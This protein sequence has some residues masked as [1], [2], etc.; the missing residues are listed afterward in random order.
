MDEFIA[1]LLGNGGERSAQ[2]PTL[3]HGALWGDRSLSAEQRADALLAEM[4]LEEKSGMLYGRGLKVSAERNIWQAWVRGVDRLGVP[5]VT[6]GDSPAAPLMGPDDGMAIPSEH[7]LGATFDPEAAQRAAFVLGAQVRRMGYGVWHAP[8]LD[9]TRDPRH[10]R[11]HENFGEDPHLV[12]IMGAAYARGLGASRVVADIKHVGMNAVE[13][14]RFTTDYEVS[15]DRFIGHYLAPFRSVIANATVPMAMTAYAKV[16]GEHVNN[17]QDIFRLLR[18][19]WGLRGVVRNDAMAAH[20]LSSLDFG[21]DQEFRDVLH[22]GD[23]LLAAVRT[24]EVDEVVVDTA[25]RRVLLMMIETGLFDDVPR[26]TWTGPTAAE[27]DTVREVAARG[28]VLLENRDETLPLDPASS[29]R[30]LVVGPAATDDMIAGGPAR[31]L[32][33]R[34]TFLDALRAAMPAAAIEY[35]P[36][37]DPLLLTDQLAGYPEIPLD[38]LN[39]GNVPGLRAEFFDADGLSLEVRYG[40]PL[41]LQAPNWAFGGGAG[42]LFAPQGTARVVWSG[43]WS[44]QEGED[45]DVVAGG[46]ARVSIDGVVVLE[47]DGLGRPGPRSSRRIEPGAGAH[48]ILVEYRVPVGDQRIFVDPTAAPLK[49][50]LAQGRHVRPAITAAAERAANADL[51]IVV[52]RDIASE[53]WDRTNLALPGRQDELITTISAA[54]P[55]TIVVLETASAV[56]TPWRG[57]VAALI[58]GW[59]GGTRGNAAIVDVL[60]GAVDPGGRLP[61]TFPEH[62]VDLPT[63]DEKRFPGVAEHVRVDEAETGYRYFDG[64]EAPRAAYPF[65]HGLS[66]TTFAMEELRGPGTIAIPE[67]A[68]TSAART[69]TL[70]L[71]VRVRNTGDRRGRCVPQVYVQQPGEPRPLLCSFASAELDPGEEVDVD[72][73]IAWADLARYRDG[74]WRIEPGVFIVHAATDARTVVASLSIEVTR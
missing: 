17:T 20:E 42:G 47:H 13:T 18:D 5:D 35:D 70:S 25:V 26:P 50:G 33:G 10:G 53:G 3:P 19:D 27:L 1:L 59:Y 48:D 21:L 30:I 40:A 6:Q 9:V 44:A 69:D 64:A 11:V 71:S 36:V 52:A 12:S 65:G 67:S 62:D 45:I 54:N 37:L 63:F 58:E 39:A 57:D 16:N 61:V 29:L 49:V 74:R 46:A 28:V 68:A 2:P 8:T 55:R 38:T 60:T 23:E 24:G 72:V 51:V 15:E 43:T 66:Y 22:F 56:L 31:P 34:D 4:T 41:A 73:S 14:D 32:R 7:S